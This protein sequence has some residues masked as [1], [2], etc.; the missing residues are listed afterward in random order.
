M[1]NKVNTSVS[2][3]YELKRKL[4]VYC[5][6]KAIPQSRFIESLIK[7]ELDKVQHYIFEGDKDYWFVSDEVKD[8]AFANVM[9]YSIHSSM[10]PI[11]CL[12]NFNGSKNQLLVLLQAVITTIE[13]NT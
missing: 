5:E 4:D 12:P 13:S 3:S 6:S 2:L 9:V 1:G 11:F 10:S 7:K 8:N